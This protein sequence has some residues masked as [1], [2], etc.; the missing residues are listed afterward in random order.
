[1]YVRFSSILVPL[2][3]T[4]GVQMPFPMGDWFKSVPTALADLIGAARFQQE[5]M[6]S[7][8]RFYKKKYQQQRALLER[9]KVELEST[10]QLKRFV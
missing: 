4:G 9:M 5:S 10:T 7:L 1:M 6:V 3:S 8:V 2:I